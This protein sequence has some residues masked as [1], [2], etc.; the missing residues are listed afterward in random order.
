MEE[1]RV[2]NKWVVAVT[3]MTP[4]TME[5]LDTSVANVSLSHIQ[6]S[7]N[8]GLEEVTWVLTSYLVANAIVLPMTGWLSTTF[9]RKRFLMVCVAGFTFFSLLCGAA[10]T[11]AALVIFRVMQG[12]F[13]GAMQPM[14]QA[15]LLE[16]FPKEEHGSAM[17]FYGM[18]IVTAPIFGPLLGGWITDEMSWRWIFYINIPIGVIS[19]LAI[20]A[21]VEDPPYL[22]KMKRK[23]DS[24]GMGLLVVGIGALQLM[25]DKGNQEDWFNSKLIT[26]CAIFAFS[27]LLLLI[28]WEIYGTENPIVNLRA[29]K[30]RS[31]STGCLLLFLTFFAFFSSIVLLPLYLQKLMGYTAFQAGIVLGPGGMATLF[32]L[33]FVGTLTQRGHARKLLIFGLVVSATSVYMMSHFNTLADFR[34]VIFPRVIQGIGMSCFFVPLTT[35]SMSGIPQEQIGNTTGIYN[36]IR[37]LGGSFGVA[38]SSTLLTTRTQF[39]QFRMTEHLDFLDPY[40]RANISSFTNFLV[41]RGIPSSLGEHAT[42][43]GLYNQVLQ[44]SM[45]LAFNDAFYVMFFFTVAVIPLVFLFKRINKLSPQTMGH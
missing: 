24:V 42:L 38:V 36:L 23:M 29:F 35:L 19:L 28:W 39:H 7:L 16:S 5:I 13:G 43:Q 9:G 44:Q 26:L 15:I 20:E 2:P 6:G 34:T 33:P 45:M 4:T 30:I 27:G 12:L 25:L 41:G 10:P 40:V 17:A 11:L 3:V 31:F 1:Y 21:V 37:N 14:S 32:M 22:K 18:G 8:A